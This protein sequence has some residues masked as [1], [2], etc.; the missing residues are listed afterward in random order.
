[1]FVLGSDLL[2]LLVA[3]GNVLEIAVALFKTIF[4]MSLTNFNLIIPNISSTLLEPRED[5]INHL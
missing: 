4:Q 3:S 2:R 5:Y 1:M